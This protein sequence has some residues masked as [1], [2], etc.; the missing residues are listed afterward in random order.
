MVSKRERF[1]VLTPDNNPPPKALVAPLLA[2]MATETPDQ[3]PDHVDIV[4]STSLLRALAG[5]KKRCD[6]FSA[7]NVCVPGFPTRSFMAVE[8]HRPRKTEDLG[9]QGRRVE[10]L[11]VGKHDCTFHSIALLKIDDITLL[12]E[13]EIDAAGPDGEV[14]EVKS[15]RKQ[16]SGGPYGPGASSIQVIINGSNTIKHVQVSPDGE[17]ALSI[18]DVKTVT[19]NNVR[20][21]QQW[22]RIREQL[23]AFVLR[24]KE[25]LSLHAHASVAV[26][27]DHEK[28]PV[29]KA[30]NE[31]GNYQFTRYTD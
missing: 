27:F 17:R 6:S 13:S 10:Q 31:C 29:F 21:T 19:I 28:N 30:R 9:D 20:E 22:K 26:T 12:V 14:M 2:K 18:N 11:V 16:P 23:P 1:Q 5:D 8:R 3:Y 25:I 15:S 24:I 7:V 4:C